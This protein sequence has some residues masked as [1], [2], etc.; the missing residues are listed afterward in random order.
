MMRTCESYRERRK[1]CE[2]FTALTVVITEKFI[3][4]DESGGNE[5]MNIRAKAL[6]DQT[7]SY[8]PTEIYI[9]TYEE[10]VAWWARSIESSYQS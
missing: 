4:N 6:N 8:L 1:T 3:G 2:P 5:H 7:Q 9:N 10:R